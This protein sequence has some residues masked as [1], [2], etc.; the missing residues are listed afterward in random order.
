MLG[1]AIM[2]AVL[3]AAQAAPLPRGEL[4]RSCW[5]RY[6][7][8]R[9]RV[10]L[11]EFTAVDF[12]N[13][14]HGDA[15][16]TPFT[17]EFAVRGMGVVPAG[18]ALPGS[19]HHHVLIDVPLPINVQEKIP[20][21]D[22]HKHFGKGQTHTVLDLPAGSHTLRL[23]FADHEHRPHYVYSKEI[24]VYVQGRRGAEPLAIDPNRF[25]ATCAAWYQDEVSRPRPA[26][27][28]L[29]IANLRDAEVVTSPFNLRFIVDGHG[30]SAAGAKVDRTGHFRL[31]VW[32]DRQSPQV[33]DLANGATQTNLFLVN[34]QYMLRLRF[35]DRTGQRDLLPPLD[36]TVVVLGQ[37]RL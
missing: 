32:R 13:L 34:G 20:F 16:R 11:K 7:K 29:A 25:D 35:V 37:D 31:E 6:T 12:S 15:V 4:E 21:S 14:R 10:N 22:T 23:L 17:V 2:V 26:G 1:G 27:D 28:W 3:A 9:T 33:I 24:T 5:Q 36:Q 19:G 8:E 18:T 30:V